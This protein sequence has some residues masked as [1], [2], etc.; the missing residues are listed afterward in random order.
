MIKLLSKSIRQFKKQSLL[1]PLFV[2]LEVVMEVII[3]VLI[4]DLMDK[5]IDGGSMSSIWYYGVLLAVSAILSLIF[6]GCSGHFAA[7]ASAGFA[8]NLRHDMY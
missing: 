3:P 1:A 4:A 5:G 2:T 6:G 8:R 7:V